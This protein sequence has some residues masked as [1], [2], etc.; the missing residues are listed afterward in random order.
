MI[1]F[2]AQRADTR[3]DFVVA[4]QRHY[5]LELLRSERETAAIVMPM[6][7][8]SQPKQLHVL[9]RA[10]MRRHRSARRREFEPVIRF[11]STSEIISRALL[12]RFAQVTDTECCF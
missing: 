1:E 5:G 2:G 11:A 12:R 7:C 4:D 3:L 8:S 9:F 10:Q 6:R